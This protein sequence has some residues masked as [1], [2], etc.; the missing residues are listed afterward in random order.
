LSEPHKIVVERTGSD[1]P[2]I[3]IHLG[4]HVKFMTEDTAQV[5]GRALQQVSFGEKKRLTVYEETT[6]RPA[7]VYTD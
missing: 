5:L 2:A 3:A 4:G 7:C 1:T 6:H